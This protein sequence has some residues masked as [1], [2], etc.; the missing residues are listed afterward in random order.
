ML[1][2]KVLHVT[3]LSSAT[4]NIGILNQLNSEFLSV[5]QLKIDW[6]TV[7]WSNDR[8]QNKIFCRKIPFIASF[9]IF[10]RLFFS[11]WVFREA[12]KFKHVLVRY[13]IC[14]PFF[15]F[16][17]FFRKNI[18]TVHHSK[19]EDIIRL[20]YNNAVGVM[21]KKVEHIIG[22]LAIKR[23]KGLIALTSD[24]LSYEKNRSNYP[25]SSRSLV[26]PN[27]IFMCNLPL[28]D[29]RR[30]DQ[31]RLLFVSSVFYPWIGL[32]ELLEDLIR[33]NIDDIQVHIDIVGVVDNRQRN[34]VQMASIKHKIILHGTLESKEVR[35]LSFMCDL[36]LATF[37]WD[38]AGLSEACTLK[39]REYLSYGLPVYSGHIDSALPRNFK[40]YKMGRPLISEIVGYALKMKLIAKES[41][42][43]E[44]KIYIDKSLLVRKVYSW[45]ESKD[46]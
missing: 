19:E 3:C 12:K 39:V 13:P 8:I 16:V 29:L 30:D 35:E 23:S 11:L 36:G 20:Q 46:G 2:N 18:Y 1:K 37:N 40:Y 41:V 5:K 15:I 21:L 38:K 4:K 17:L 7:F 32:N 10:R 6:S 28:K 22:S 42:K 43:N 25:L 26:S 45:L 27:G 33:F 44:S 24:I 31:V 34:L 14:D 9:G